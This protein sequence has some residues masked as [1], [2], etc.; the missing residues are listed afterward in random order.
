MKIAIVTATIMITTGTVANANTVVDFDGLAL[1]NNESYYNGSDEAGSFQSGPVTFFNNYNSAY[2]SWDG[3]AYSNMSDTTTADFSNQYSAITGH[4][5]GAGDDIY[6]VAYYSTYASMKP[7]F[8]LD[9][10]TTVSGLQITNATYT[11]LSMKNG[12]SF[13]KKFGG[14]TGNDADWLKVTFTGILSGQSVGD[15]DFYLADYRFDNQ[16]DDYIVDSWEWVDLSALGL[17]DKIEITMTSSD[18]GSFGINTPT[19][20]AID[21]VTLVPEPAGGVLLGI[22]GLALLRRRE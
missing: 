13:A 16:L 12:D 10:A 18:V 17:V 6:A 8:S 2:G 5:A 11:A 7:T 9:E 1:A 22:S 4:G 20:F 14:A 3:F 21:N 15:I 19:Y